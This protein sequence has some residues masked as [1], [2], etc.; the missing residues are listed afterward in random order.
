MVVSSSK[1]EPADKRQPEHHGERAANFDSDFVSCLAISDWSEL[2]FSAVDSK[3]WSGVL[4]AAFL[5]ILIQPASV[6]R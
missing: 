1:T 2:R 3:T 5:A 6:D 4:L